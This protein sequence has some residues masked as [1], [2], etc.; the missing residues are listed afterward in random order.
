MTGPTADSI[1]ADL[2]HD[3]ETYIREHKPRGQQVETGASQLYGCIAEGIFRLRGEP[4]QEP[5]SWDAE[6]GTAVHEYL[7]TVRPKVRDGVTVERRFVFRNVPATV[8]YID[9]PVLIDYKTDKDAD[10]ILG[11]TEE[12]PKWRAQVMLG[13]AGAREAGY[14]VEYVAIVVLPRSGDL[15]DAKVFGPWPYDEAE[16][17]A[18]AAWAGDV[19]SLA[20]DP[21]VDPRDHRGMPAFWCWSYCGFAKA[22]RGER[23]DAPDMDELAPIA[24]D[25]DDA[26]RAEKAAVARKKL[27]A[28]HL[29][30]VRDL[31]DR[32]GIAGD[33]KVTA[34]RN[35]GRSGPDVEAYEE[36]WRFVHG[37]DAE[38]PT[39]RGAPYEYPKVTRRPKDGKK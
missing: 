14:Q 9:L 35:G 30:V 12:K 38:L 17:V 29:L 4:S 15:S 36:L 28:P 18:A 13:A 33:F 10:D 26:M 24:E 7:A 5:L 16:A 20:A 22:C 27:L 8:D 39:R 2:R 1:L 6:V 21:D 31:P 19:D 32:T 37:A 34:V 25:Y 3:L 23:P 11:L